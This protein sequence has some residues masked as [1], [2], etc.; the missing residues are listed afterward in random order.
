MATAAPD[1]LV[2]YA[3]DFLLYIIHYTRNIPASI[4]RLSNEKELR[5]PMMTKICSIDWV[6][7][8]PIIDNKF[9]PFH[10]L[11]QIIFDEFPI[12]IYNLI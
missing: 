6:Q 4:I 10:C 11:H 2:R 1:V 7:F 12:N 5:I 9:G 8:C 3:F